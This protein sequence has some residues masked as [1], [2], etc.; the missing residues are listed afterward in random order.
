MSTEPTLDDKTLN[1]KE[2]LSIVKV[3]DVEY[4]LNIDDHI[5]TNGPIK[6]AQEPAWLSLIHI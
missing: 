4:K 1:Q 2:G 6:F 5:W 3:R